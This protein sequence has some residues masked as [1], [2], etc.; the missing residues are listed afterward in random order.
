MGEILD[1]LQKGGGLQKA[2]TVRKG[3]A[4]DD[5]GSQISL[6]DVKVSEIDPEELAKMTPRELEDHAK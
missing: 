4:N 6:Y 3:A 5:A 1:D 2:K